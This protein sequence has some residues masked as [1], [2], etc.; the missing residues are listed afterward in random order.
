FKSPMW[1]TP[2][3]P[4]LSA[5]GVGSHGSVLSENYAPY[6]LSSGCKSTDGILKDFTGI[7]Q[8]DAYAGYNRLIQPDR[9]GPAIQLAYCWAHARRKLY[10]VARNSTAPIAEDGLTRIAELY[11]IETEI[12]GFAPSARLAVRQ[13]QS[14]PKIADLETWLIHH[15]ARVSA[16]SP[17]GEALKYIAKYWTGLIRFLTDGRIE[18]GNN[19]VERTIRPIALNRK[20]A[21]FAG[22]DAGA[23]NWATIASLVETC[24][25]NT[26]EPHAYLK[27][28]LTAIVNGHR[29]SQID[30]L[31]P[32]NYAKH[33]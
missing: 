29:Q 31:L 30:D 17:L 11:K 18:L 13:D 14:A 19:A 33:V 3:P 23:E 20:N 6:R 22:H 25:L 24:K 1:I 4:L 27:A 5:L 32:W 9:V 10:E 8:V 21:L 16:K 28:T 12:R 15:R 2:L 7:L 26:I